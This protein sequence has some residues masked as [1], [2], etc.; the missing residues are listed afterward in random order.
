[1]SY[2]VT[3]NEGRPVATASTLESAQSFAYHNS[4]SQRPSY[5]KTSW[6]P[7]GKFYAGDRWT[8]WEVTPV[9]TVGKA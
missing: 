6:T 5:G 2:V 8:G 7:T 4:T 1:M 9:P 3:N